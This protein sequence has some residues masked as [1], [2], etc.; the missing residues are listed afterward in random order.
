MF[1][2]H[3]RTLPAGQFLPASIESSPQ[4]PASVID[5]IMTPEQFFT[6]AR[7]SAASWSGEQRL[8]LAVL[9]D[10]IANFLRYKGSRTTRG[11]RLFRE[12]CEWFWSQEKHYLYAF[13][14]ICDYLHLDPDYLR[15]GLQKLRLRVS[16]VPWIMET[17]RVVSY[18]RV[19]V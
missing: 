12:E 9:E 15:A 13:E 4:P 5:E 18:R 7:H 14:T 6:Y 19:E 11:R 8:L 17:G 2:E 3:V 10:A 16:A 1:S